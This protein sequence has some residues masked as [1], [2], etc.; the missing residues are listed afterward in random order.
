MSLIV[1]PS[2]A[3]R[4]RTASTRLGGS[5]NVTDAVGSATTTGRPI[6]WALT[7]RHREPA[8]QRHGSLRHALA[9]RE[10]PK[11]RIEPFRLL[12]LG[13]SRHMTY[14][15]YLLRRKS[16]TTWE[17]SSGIA[18]SKQKLPFAFGEWSHPCWR[19]STCAGS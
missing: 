3:A 17:R 2:A 6:I 13:R 18:R 10:Q 4:A 1:I 14:T 15:Y 11:G 12:R 16:R 7:T 8:R 19:I 5:L 9:T